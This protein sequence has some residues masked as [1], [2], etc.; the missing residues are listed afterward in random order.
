MVFR[1]ILALGLILCF[2]LSSCSRETTDT[3]NLTP[4]QSEISTPAIT[5]SNTPI[6]D[7]R[8]VVDG[9]VEHSLSLTYEM[10]LQYP[11][12]T[13]QLLLTCPGVFENVNEWTGVPLSAILN[14]VG[15]KKDAARVK[16][17]SPGGY[18]SELSIEEAL[19]DGTFLAYNVD[20]HVMTEGDGYPLRLVAKDQIGAVWVKFL[21]HIEVL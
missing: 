3:N 2:I 4:S 14:E 18:S 8:L 11:A 16:F 9:L 20:G 17:Y 1:L 7:Y 13:E 12:V 10:I 5:P 15:L 19:K 21:D 6:S